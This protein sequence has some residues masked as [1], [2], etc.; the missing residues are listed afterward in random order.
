MKPSGSG[1]LNDSLKEFQI[2]VLS[3]I[4][5]THS[6]L[7]FLS[8]LGMITFLVLVMLQVFSKFGDLVVEST[9]DE[10]GGIIVSA[11]I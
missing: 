5:L 7:K 4:F 8:K 10:V 11:T 1:F 2:M 3:R 9:E 6:N